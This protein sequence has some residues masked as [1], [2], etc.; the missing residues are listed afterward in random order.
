MCFLRG[1][2]LAIDRDA[3]VCGLDFRAELCDG[4]AIDGHAPRRDELFRIAPRRHARLREDF[5]QTFLQ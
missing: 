2:R 5:L 1:K 3:H 4:L